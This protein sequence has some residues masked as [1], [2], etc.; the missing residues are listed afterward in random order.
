MPRFRGTWGQEVTPSS[1]PSPPEDATGVWAAGRGH[2]IAPIWMLCSALPTPGLVAVP[3]PT[4]HRSM[5]HGI[6]I[7][8]MP[9]PQPAATLGHT[10]PFNP[11]TAK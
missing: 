6:N 8:S 9:S 7:K 10:A 4:A 3:P 5:E 2:L 11:F 1:F